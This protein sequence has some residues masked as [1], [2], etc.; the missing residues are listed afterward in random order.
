MRGQLNT[1]HLLLEVLDDG[2]ACPPGIEG[3]VVVTDLT[4]RGM[5]FIRY[6]NGDRAIAATAPC[7]CGRGLPMLAAVTG[8]RLDVLQT[9]DGG[10]LPGEFF[11][12][13]LKEVP[14]V[15]RFQVIQE[16]IGRIQLRVVAPDWTADHEA[17][18]RRELAAVAPSLGL[19]I[20][21]VDHIPLTAAGK[22]QVVVNRVA[23][24]PQEAT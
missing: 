18:L 23:A 7:A 22:L 13:L 17:W 24:A 5:P 10:Q 15:Q 14:A 3:N 19:T 6:A 21:Q 9:P 16:E 1:E 11:P 2:P 4:N 20:T 12:H 8:R